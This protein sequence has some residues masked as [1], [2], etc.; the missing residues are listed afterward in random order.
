MADESNTD[1]TQTTLEENLT[2]EQLSDKQ[3]EQTEGETGQDTNFSEKKHPLRFKYSFWFVRR[4]QGS[5]N[6][7]S[8]EKNIKNVGN[9][10]TV[11]DY[12]AYYNHLVRPNDLQY[13]CDYQLF[14]CGIKP[15]WEDDANKRGGKFI[16]RIPKKKR[17]ASKWWEDLLLAF[18]GEQFG[19]GDE[20]CGVVV[21]IR[22]QEDII[23]VWNRDCDNTEAKKL[24]HETLKRI[25]N[26]PSSTILEYKAHDQA[27]KDHSSFRN[28][29]QINA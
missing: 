16:I 17:L 18:I 11:E 24:I 3:Q 8:Y 22:Y 26:L 21:S 13:S 19:V 15:L 14:K 4:M 23:S 25:F 12:W 7:E 27:I 9:F 10:D 5:R 28:T 20:I 2:N 1:S 29:E 6:A